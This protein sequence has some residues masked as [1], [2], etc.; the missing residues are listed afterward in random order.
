MKLRSA[1]IALAACLGAAVA[2]A[3]APA[4][5][6][7]VPLDL[8]GPRPI[9]MLSVG[10]GPPARVIFDTGAS[11]NVIDIEYARAAGLPDEGPAA[12][13]APAGQPM[14]GFRTVIAEGRL[15]NASIAGARAVALETPTLRHLE[16]RGVFGPSTF[17]GRLVHLDLARGE[18]RITDKNPGSIPA[19]PSSPYSGGL[20][21]LPG[22]PGIAVDIAGTSFDAHIDTGHP[23]LLMMPLSMASRV[24]LDGELRQ[25]ARPARFADGV[26]R[27]LFEGRIRGTVRVGPLT[28]ENP[29][30]RFMDGLN[31]VN[32]GMTALRGMTLV[33]DPAERRSWL[34]RG[35]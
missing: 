16:V 22:L 20:G 27:N 2:A 4:D 15:G 21:Q 35:T 26:P 11:G 19:G 12:V 1:G 30:V 23:G 17:S 33:L 6:D 34:V 28:F 8:S 24:P 25:A 7:V 29:E 5:P 18:I 32:V 13:H 9:A 14:Q 3:Q 31:R 10:A